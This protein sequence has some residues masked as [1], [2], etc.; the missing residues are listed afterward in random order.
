MTVRDFHPV[1]DGSLPIF[2][3][4]ARRL[5]TV[6]PASCCHGGMGS[7]IVRERGEPAVAAVRQVP[8]TE[9]EYQPG[10]TV[11]ACRIGTQE[12]L[13]ANVNIQ[14]SYHPFRC[15]SLRNWHGA[16]SVLDG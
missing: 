8:V 16:G 7:Y 5:P 9:G 12:R 1:R 14:R 2:A 6:I 3:R 15:A 4:V 11:S 10:T 13:G